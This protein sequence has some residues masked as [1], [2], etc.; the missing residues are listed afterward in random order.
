MPRAKAMNSPKGKSQLEVWKAAMITHLGARGASP[1]TFQPHAFRHVS[2]IQ[3]KT[4]LTTGV[5][6]TV[7][8]MRAGSFFVL[9]VLAHA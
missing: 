1:L 7:Y 9:R 4:D 2:E 8:C 3:R 5:S 6:N